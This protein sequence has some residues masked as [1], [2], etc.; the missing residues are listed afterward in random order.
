MQECSI[1]RQSLEDSVLLPSVSSITNTDCYFFYLHLFPHHCIFIY[2]TLYRSFYDHFPINTVTEE[3]EYFHVGLYYVLLK[4][5]VFAFSYLHVF[6]LSLFVSF[7]CLSSALSPVCAI[8]FL[9]L[10]LSSCI[11]PQITYVLLLT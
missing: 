2:C 4:T 5:H 7:N 8:T 1:I 9:F 10:L 11:Y 3:L 6:L